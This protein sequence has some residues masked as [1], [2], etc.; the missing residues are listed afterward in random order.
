MK[1]SG[2]R[3]AIFVVQTFLV[4]AGIFGV[5]LG[6]WMWV[7]DRADRSDPWD[8]LTGGIGAVFGIWSA[9]VLLMGLLT[10]RHI[11]RH[12]HRVPLLAIISGVIGLSPLVATAFHVDRVVYVFLSPFAL[13]LLLGLVAFGDERPQ[14]R[15]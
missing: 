1:C 8:G 2:I 14:M 5:A 7:S 11:I 13:L 15:G 3:S 10:L 4:A 6:T 12:T 9:V